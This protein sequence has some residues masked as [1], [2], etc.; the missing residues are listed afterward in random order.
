MS[1]LAIQILA[2]ALFL[3][4]ILSG[5][6]LM[7]HLTSLAAAFEDN[8]DLV[9]ADAR[10]RQSKT[11]LIIAMTVLIGGAGGCLLLAMLIASGAVI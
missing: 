1:V 7:L 10:P 11:G 3:S 5:V 6:W 9:S 4:S 2:A 8:A